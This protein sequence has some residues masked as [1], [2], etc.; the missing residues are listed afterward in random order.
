MPWS[1]SLRTSCPSVSTGPHKIPP[2]L[3]RILLHHVRH[4]NLSSAAH[5]GGGMPPRGTE[6]TTLKVVNSP[7]E[8][9]SIFVMFNTLMFRALYRKT[10]KE[11]ATQ[12]D[13][14]LRFLHID[15]ARIVALYVLYV[16]PAYVLARQSIDP[17]FRHNDLL[18]PLPFGRP[19]PSR[20]DNAFTSATQ[21]QHHGAMPAQIY[22]QA[23]ARAFE[24]TTEFGF[25]IPLAAYRQLAVSGTRGFLRRDTDDMH[26]MLAHQ[27]GHSALTRSNQYGTYAGQE[28]GSSEDALHR[29]FLTSRFVHRTL[30][31]S[32]AVAPLAASPAPLSVSAATA[33]GMSAATAIGM[34]P[35]LVASPTTEELRPRRSHPLA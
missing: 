24:T 15:A 18:F 1:S 6:A 33:I 12:K 20:T 3:R 22:N 25:P 13:V 21:P 2:T 10:T 30:G 34:S 27:A 5:L 8:Q 23:V 4:S 7:T 26:D 16:R 28:I 29:G 35:R 11:G 9:R 14:I 31:Y 19:A 17:D 32:E